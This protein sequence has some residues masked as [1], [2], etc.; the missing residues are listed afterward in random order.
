GDLGADLLKREENAGRINIEVVIDV[1]DQTT[2]GSDDAGHKLALVPVGVGAHAHDLAA[3]MMM[4]KRARPAGGG[5]AAVELK[6]VERGDVRRDG[7]FMRTRPR[8]RGGGEGLQN[9]TL[10]LMHVAAVKV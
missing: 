2:V 9:H 5:V 1:N 10:I 4:R 7:D 3:G 6:A 8:D